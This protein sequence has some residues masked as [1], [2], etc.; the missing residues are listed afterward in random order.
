MGKHKV[1]RVIDPGQTAVQDPSGSGMY[2]VPDP[3]QPYRHDDPLVT[4][5]PWLF[6]ADE[7]AVE[8]ADQRPGEKRTVGRPRHTPVYEQGDF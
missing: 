5:Y 6:L 8:S 3:R 2:V 1:Y 4:A 7:D